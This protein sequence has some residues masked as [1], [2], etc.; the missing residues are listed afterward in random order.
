MADFGWQELLAD[1][2]E[3]EQKLLMSSWRNSTINTYRPAWERWKK[4]C[5]LHSI[6]YKLPKAEQVA[7]YL[8]HLH[9]DI[10]LSYRTI[11][12]HKSVISTFTNLTANIDLS[13]NFFIKHMLKAIS[14]ARERPINAP[15]WNPKLLLEY[16]KSHSL[17]QNNIYQVSRVTATLLLL[18]S[19]RRVHDLTLL[20]IDGNSL[21][22]QN[23]SIIL[24]PAFGSK[25]DS[26]R[27]RQ[28]GWKLR[29]HP[30]KNLNIVFWIKQLLKITIDR[31]KD[32]NHLFITA[33]GDPKPASKTVIAGWIK[34]LM[35]DAGIESSPGSIR[36]AVASL[37]W[38]ENFTIDKILET[39]N[40]KTVHTF[41][42]Y[43]QKEI[44]DFNECNRT[45]SVSLSNYFDSV[46]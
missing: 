33:R 23:N 18:A 12:V 42:K 29:Q 36:S 40:W 1:W 32:I 15:I 2:T 20:R 19:G 26:I 28:S 8:A 22:N 3:Q 17:N 14:I 13:S 31:R 9:C 10:G 37:N 30:D 4:W 41:R 35:K 43:Y 44:I 6:N 27:H 7:R 39:G 5:E 25:T 45:E 16:I 24:W 46:H 38:L 34:S 11:L 21:I